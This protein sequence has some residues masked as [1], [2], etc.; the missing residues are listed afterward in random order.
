MASTGPKAQGKNIKRGVDGKSLAELSGIMHSSHD[1]FPVA[2]I[3]VHCVCEPKSR[4]FIIVC[5]EPHEHTGAL[6][7]GWREPAN[8]KAE[9]FSVTIGLAPNLLHGSARA[10][11][12]PYLYQGRKNSLRRY[13]YGRQ[14]VKG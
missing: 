4:D 13:E 9:E 5:V 1:D 7:D 3:V 14:I 12:A 10:R 8:S 11:L 6:G 2:R